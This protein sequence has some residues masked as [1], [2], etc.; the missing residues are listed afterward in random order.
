MLGLLVKYT[1]GEVALFEDRREDC[2]GFAGDLLSVATAD[3]SL[4]FAGARSFKLKPF[5]SF[6]LILLATLISR[7]VDLGFI[8]LIKH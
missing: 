8:F 1:T 2:T 3:T 7:W 4:V 6:I 5:F